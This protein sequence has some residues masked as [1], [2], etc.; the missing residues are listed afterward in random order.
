MTVNSGT[1]HTPTGTVTL[2][3]GTTQ[4]DTF[5]LTGGQAIA[6]TSALAVGSHVITAVY[7][8][9]SNFNGSTSAV[10]SQVVLVR[11]A[12]D[13]AVRLTDT[14]GLVLQGSEA[15]YTFTVSNHG[16][17]GATNVRLTHVCPRA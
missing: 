3:D 10:V 2:F 14:P 13:L 8:G 4:L 12:A 9:D 15:A 11:P 6:T 7:N 1:G 5:T 17:S 16:P